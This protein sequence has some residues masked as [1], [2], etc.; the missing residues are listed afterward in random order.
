MI[1]DTIQEDPIPY[2]STSIVTFSQQNDDIELRPKSSWNPDW[3]IQN[4]ISINIEYIHHLSLFDFIFF[5]LF[6][7]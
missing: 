7:K 1:M 5:S 2:T 3:T 6:F 4:E